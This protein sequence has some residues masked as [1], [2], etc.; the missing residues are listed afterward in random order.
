MSLR[1]RSFLTS[2]S[3]ISFALAIELLLTNAS[4]GITLPPSEKKTE[5]I[6]GSVMPIDN[7][8]SFLFSTQ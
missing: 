4:I 5:G 8:P 2:A 7:T 6:G 1:E 3:L